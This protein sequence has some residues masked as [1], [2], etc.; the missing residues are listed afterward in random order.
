MQRQMPSLDQALAALIN[1]LSRT[2]QL[3][4]TL[5]MVSSEFDVRPRSIKTL[6]AITG[7]RSS[8]SC[9]QRRHQGRT[10]LR[11]VEFDGQRTDTDPIGPEDLAT[12]VYNQLGIVA[13]K[14]LMSPGDRPIEICD[15][16][17]VVKALLA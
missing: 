8:A 10:D 1:D 3:A 15:G 5:V 9:L 16:G 6:A 4:N 2:G 12:T 14:E 11:L 17:K 13:D 7:R